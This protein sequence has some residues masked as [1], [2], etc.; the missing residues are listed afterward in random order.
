MSRARAAGSSALGAGAESARLAREARELDGRDWQSTG[1]RAT[2]DADSLRSFAAELAGPPGTPYAGGVWKLTVAL[3]A[4]YPFEPPAVRFVTPSW[5]PN[6]S[7]E[8]GAICLDILKKAWTPA[9]TIKTA[10]LSIGARL[11]RGTARRGAAR[12]SAA[13]RR[14]RATAALRAC[15]LPSLSGALLA[16]PEPSDPQDA[17]VAGQYIRDRAGFEETAKFWRDSYA[18]PTPASAPASA[19]AAASSAAAAAAP[20]AARAPAP[21]PAAAPAVD[22]ARVTD[23]VAM[24]F[25]RPAAAAALRANDGDLEAAMNSL[26]I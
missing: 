19:P 10:L 9:M 12:R 23:L 18:A 1:V 15:P 6:I 13:R 26:L 22:E 3:P 21:A 2:P 8:T 24:G 4:A 7:S 14:P 17:E 5:H 20:T 11:S 25:E 16:A